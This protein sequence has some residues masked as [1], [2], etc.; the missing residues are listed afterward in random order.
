MNLPV[1]YLVGAI[2][3]GR[4]EDIA[5]REQVID[6]LYG[7]AILLN[8]LAGKTYNETTKRWTVHGI[9]PSAKYIYRHDLDC[10]RKADIIVA[11]MTALSE[12]YPNIGSLLEIGGAA[13]L[14]KLIYLLID[15]DYTGH[16][17]QTM[18]KLHPFLDEA[19]VC[20]FHTLAEMIEYLDVQ[21]D[22]LSG[23]K[24]WYVPA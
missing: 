9:D 6:K 15:R 17:N 14:G 18:Y 3:D 19:A 21:V 16:E 4:P 2:R 11:N 7:R 1:I 23:R 22:M 5:W 8:P 20:V 12:R 24:P 13:I 10:V